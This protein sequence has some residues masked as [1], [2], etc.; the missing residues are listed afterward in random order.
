MTDKVRSHFLAPIAALGGR[1]QGR[2]RGSGLPIPAPLPGPYRWT[3]GG[4]P[5][6]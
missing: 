5:P 4:L 2:G 6:Y 3:S 1:S